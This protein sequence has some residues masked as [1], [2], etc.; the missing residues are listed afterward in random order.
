M[1]GRRLAEMKAEGTYIGKFATQTHFFGYEGRCAAP[2]NFDADYCYS[3]GYTAAML[4][5]EGRTGL[6]VVGTQYDSSGRRVDCRRRACYDDDE[7]GTS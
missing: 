7:Y 6:Y 1:V 5:G 4:I 3:L 2:S